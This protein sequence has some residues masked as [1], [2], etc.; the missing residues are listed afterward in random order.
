MAGCMG[1]M[2]G[3]GAEGGNLELRHDNLFD[4]KVLSTL[5][6]FDVIHVGAA[7][8]EDMI[9]VL[10]QLLAPGGRLVVPVGPPLGLQ[11]LTVFDK[12]LDGS[13]SRHQEVEVRVMPLTRPAS[14]I[15]W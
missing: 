14:Q 12:G 10:T 8:T 5:G 3:A 6:A 2:M 4:E 7:A 1:V 11:W 9:P 13:L 15:V